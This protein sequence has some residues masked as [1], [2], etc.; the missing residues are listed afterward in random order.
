MKP[1]HRRALIDLAAR[2]GEKGFS[3]VIAE[4]IEEYLNSEPT[5]EER[6]KALLSLAGS[7]PEKDADDLRSS[8]AALRGTWR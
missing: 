4:A 8:T 6:R 1:E 3:S 2:R 7:L 5:R